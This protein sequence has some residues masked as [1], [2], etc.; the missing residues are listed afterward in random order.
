MCPISFLPIRS[1]AAYTRIC[2][3]VIRGDSN[4]QVLARN[5]PAYTGENHGAS[6]IIAVAGSAKRPPDL[7]LV[8]PRRSE[9]ARCLSF[10]VHLP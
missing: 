4:P 8:Y 5:I 7:G 6:S 10:L 9:V 3:K 1:R 2:L